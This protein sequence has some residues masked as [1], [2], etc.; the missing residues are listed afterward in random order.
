[1]RCP[2][3]FTYEIRDFV[4]GNNNDTI[5]LFRAN[6]YSSDE[7]YKHGFVVPIGSTIN[8]RLIKIILDDGTVEVLA[9]NLFSKEDYIQEIFKELYFMRWGI[10]TN[11]N[12]I[13]Y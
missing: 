7:L 1:M 6:K 11:F 8:V 13:K 3:M 9:T 4:S 5:V 12:A 10:E 2:L